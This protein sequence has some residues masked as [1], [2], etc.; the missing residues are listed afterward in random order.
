MLARFSARHAA[1]AALMGLTASIASAIPCLETTMTLDCPSAFCSCVG[2]V[3]SIC[4]SKDKI[5]S[6]CADQAT[7]IAWGKEIIAGN[8]FANI[9][10]ED[11][12]GLAEFLPGTCAWANGEC[13]CPTAAPPVNAVWQQEDFFCGATE[14]R[15]CSRP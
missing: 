5:W 4:L 8:G 15:T 2:V 12:C 6:R 11:G 10:S 9:F 1:L 7:T 13:S 3:E 14:F